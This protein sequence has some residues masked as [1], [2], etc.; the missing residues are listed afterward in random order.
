[1]AAARSAI[2]VGV[3]PPRGLGAA[4]ARR[5]AREGFH[6]TIMGRTPEKLDAALGELRTAGF[7]AEAVVGD[8][9]DAERVR[10]TVA[11]ADRADAPLEAAI[12]NAGGN[13]PS[14]FLDID[15][16][17]FEE[18]WRV[19]ALGG[20]LFAQ[21]ALGAMLPRQ[22]GT[23]LFTGASASLRGRANFGA[24]AAAKAALRALAQSAAREF[25]PQGIHVAHVVVDGAID[26]DRINTFLP[27]LKEAKGADGLLDPDAI[28]EN[29]W[30]L[31]AQRR[32]AWSHEI[33]VRPWVE[34]W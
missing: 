31:H 2:V 28:A 7:A 21:A 8:V 18:M 14:P 15:P 33:D 9:T 29:Y 27:G 26:G 34:S 24:F 23:L 22:R 3:G 30:T 5:F 16:A 12:F 11:A 6:V 4:I 19:N 25:G 1:M 10:A 13:W 32:S 20:L 17:F